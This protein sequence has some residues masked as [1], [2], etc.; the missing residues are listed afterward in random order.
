VSA[1]RR[2]VLF[3]VESL[4]LAQVV[5][6]AALAEQLDP[7][8]YEVHFA[9]SEFDA[10]VFAGTA[11]RTWKIQTLDR[12]TAFKRLERGQRIYES[13]VLNG[14]V[15]EELE[16]FQRVRPDLVVGD[17]RWSLSVSAALTKVPL[18]TL[19]NAYWSPYAVRSEF[20]VPDHPIVKLIGAKRAAAYFPQVVPKVFEHFAAPLNELRVE[21]GL[22]RIGG[23]L[24]VLSFGSFTLYPDVPE[25]CPTS[26]LPPSH[27]YLG[28]IPWS[29]KLDPA[30]FLRGIDRERPLVYVTLGSSGTLAAL[31]KVLAVLGT[32]P[33]TALLSTAD[34]RTIEAPPPNV[35][36]ARYL[37]GSAIARASAFVITNG[38]SSTG[39]QALAEGKPVLGIPS[40]LDQY[41]AM[42]AIERAGAGVLIRGGEVSERALQ[43]A[44][45]RLLE[46]NAL[47]GAAAAL[48]RTF[49]L[50]DC[51]ARF[52]NFLNEAFE[53]RL[54][55]RSVS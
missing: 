23:L 6:L 31:D 38:G 15:E 21:R 3:V 54:D 33:V 17:F 29:P 50:Y 42:S 49:A 34:R 8:Q 12:A 44:L 13:S 43:S 10:L 41:L 53:G 28:A 22:S 52:A 36:V 2:R 9:A 37:P 1:D 19:I 27:R 25:L 11:F 24:E 20:P 35:R 30:E 26:N 40:N 55:A 46:P 45:F 5:R 4:T 32:L 14:Y 7:G 39:Y 16:L 18:V 48:G 51:H 47:S